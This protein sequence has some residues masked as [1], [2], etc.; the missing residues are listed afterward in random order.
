MAAKLAL[1]LLGAST[2]AIASTV[3]TA[4]AEAEARAVAE[5]AA[6]GARARAEAPLEEL[7]RGEVRS[8]LP[9]P[10]DL[11][12]RSDFSCRVEAVIRAGWEGG[13]FELFS[14]GWRAPQPPSLVLFGSSASNLHSTGADLDMTLLVDLPHA[15]QCGCLRQLE[16]LFTVTVT[17]PLP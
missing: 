2:G 11:R 14:F 9:G 5:A 16:R 10:D 15:A 1:H 3:E 4:L 6:A 13:Q 8:L 17:L 12:E 7:L